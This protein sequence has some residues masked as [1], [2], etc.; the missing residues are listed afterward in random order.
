MRHFE[1]FLDKIEFWHLDLAVLIHTLCTPVL[2]GVWD[3]D[4]QTKE[5]VLV[6]LVLAM[7]VLIP[8]IPQTLWNRYQ[9]RQT[10]EKF[11]KS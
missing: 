9:L 3:M 8:Y 4:L 5:K 2:A 1:K 10:I 6:H 7:M 11:K